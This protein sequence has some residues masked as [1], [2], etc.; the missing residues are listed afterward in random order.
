MLDSITDMLNIIRNG[1]A[2]LKEAVVVPFSN[3]N[4]EI[5]KILEENKFTGKVEKKGKKDKKSIEI[6]LKYEQDSDNRQ[7]KNPTITNIK[8]ISKP[9]KRIYRGYDEIKMSTG[10]KGIIIVSTPKG[11]MT[12]KDARKKKLG[13]EV[14]S[15]IW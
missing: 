4:Y 3:I 6:N 15:E 12:G 10:S 2:V 5:A 13:G 1:Q 7:K 11:V 9:G 8:R 14:I